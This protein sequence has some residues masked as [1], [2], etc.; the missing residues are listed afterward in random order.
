M[1]QPLLAS[2]FH[3]D[4]RKSLHDCKQHHPYLLHLN[5]SGANF[6]MDNAI[7]QHINLAEVM[8]SEIRKHSNS[9]QR[10]CVGNTDDSSIFR[11]LEIILAF[12]VIE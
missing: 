8:K 1:Q 12:S 9:R 11:K 3:F 4:W 5:V 2:R 10:F 6:T 7:I